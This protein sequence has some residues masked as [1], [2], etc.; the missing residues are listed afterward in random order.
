MVHEVV[1]VFYKFFSLYIGMKE[2]Q[3][4]F[5]N[6]NLRKNKKITQKEKPEK[7][8]LDNQQLVRNLINVSSQGH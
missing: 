2:N 3:S 8:L 5:K 4:H 1:Q 6:F 7:F